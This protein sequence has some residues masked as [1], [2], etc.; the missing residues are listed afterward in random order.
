MPLDL[1]AV[2]SAKRSVA[3]HEC[4]HSKANSPEKVRSENKHSVY[5]A[6][7]NTLAGL[8]QNKAVVSNENERLL[9]TLSVSKYKESTANGNIVRLRENTL[10]RSTLLIER[11]NNNG[12]KR[13]CDKI[14]RR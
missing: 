3:G 6:D 1:V 11:N 4:S 2:A 9:N 7:M 13:V 5:P 8:I 10:T 14:H 12:R